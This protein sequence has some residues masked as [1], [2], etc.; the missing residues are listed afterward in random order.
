[1]RGILKLGYLAK[2]M[3]ASAPL[4]TETLFVGGARVVIALLSAK[5][6]VRSEGLPLL[7]L[8]SYAAFGSF[9]PSTGS[10]GGSTRSAAPRAR[11]TISTTTIG[12]SPTSSA[13]TRTQMTDML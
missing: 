11:P 6:A 4:F 12:S 13:A 8:F 9:R 10:R 3:E 5:G 7:A 2:T 1:M